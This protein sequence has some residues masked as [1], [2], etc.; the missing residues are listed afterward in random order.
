MPVA[1]RFRLNHALDVYPVGSGTP[2]LPLFPEYVGVDGLSVYVVAVVVQERFPGNDNS[3]ISSIFVTNVWAEN[4]NLSNVVARIAAF[5]AEPRHTLIAAPR[6]N[7]KE[8]LARL[9]AAP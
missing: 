7:L 5:A 8:M 9:R 3:S 1:F 4:T 2:R 6:S